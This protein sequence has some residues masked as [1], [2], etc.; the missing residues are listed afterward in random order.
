MDQILARQF[1]FIGMLLLLSV[2]GIGCGGETG[3][4]SPTD[5]PM[6]SNL[7]HRVT[8]NWSSSKSPD[9]EGYYVYR[10]EQPG[11]PY[12]KISYL[13]PGTTYTDEAV[14]AG[15]TYYYVVTALGRNSA[16]SG[17]S[18]EALASVP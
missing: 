2:L 1:C 4:T 10:G 6:P 5:T 15:Q 3:S 14:A 8:L 13:L 18:N 16:E 7:S 11:G 12:A 9:L 17:Y